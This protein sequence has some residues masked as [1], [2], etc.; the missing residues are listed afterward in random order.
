[1]SLISGYTLTEELN[2]QHNNN[3]VQQK[4]FSTVSI[5]FVGNCFYLF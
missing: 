2:T 3:D 4:S 5:E 1:M